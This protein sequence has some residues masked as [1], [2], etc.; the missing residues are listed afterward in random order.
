MSLER[1]VGQL[2]RREC[3][4]QVVSHEG[5]PI[6]ADL[7]VKLTDTNTTVIMS[8]FVVEIEVV[9]RGGV[10]PWNHHATVRLTCRSLEGTNQRVY[11]LELGWYDVDD[12]VLPTMERVVSEAA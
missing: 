12:V 10:T 3:S 9:N 1:V 8:V 4:T 6:R 5:A 2:L 7:R 11:C